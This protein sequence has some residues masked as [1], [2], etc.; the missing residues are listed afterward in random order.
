ML[1]G[2]MCCGV[3]DDDLILRLGPKQADKALKKLHTRPF[4]ITG[5][6]MKGFIVVA[7][8]GYKT[9]EALRRWLRQATDFAMSLPPK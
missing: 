8:R 6:S 7:P 4:D 2:N 5:R 1:R 3:L 9:G